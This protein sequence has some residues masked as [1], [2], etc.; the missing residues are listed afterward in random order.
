MAKLWVTCAVVMAQTGGE[1]AMW[2]QGICRGRTA[3]HSASRDWAHKGS[4]DRVMDRA[5]NKLIIIFADKRPN[6]ILIV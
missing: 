5:V 3:S 1:R 4:Q 2:R 6:F